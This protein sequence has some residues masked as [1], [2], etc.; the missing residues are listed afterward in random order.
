MKE[1]SNQ[2]RQMKWSGQGLR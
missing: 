1:S 2:N